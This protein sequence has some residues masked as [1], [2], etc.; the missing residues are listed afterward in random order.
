[1]ATTKKR[2]NTSYTIQTVNNTDIVTL[3]TSQVTITGNLSVLGVTTYVESTTTQVKD[4][5]IQLNQGETGA[6]VTGGSSGIEIDRGSSPDVQLRWNETV[7]A[8]QITSDGSTYS[9]IAYTTGSGFA[10]SVFSD[11]EPSV[12][13]NLNMWNYAIYSNTQPVV[14]FSDNVSISTTSVAPT[15][16]VNNVVVYASTVSGGGS[17]LYTSTADGANELATKSA[18]IKYSIIF[19]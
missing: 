15:A 14:Y 4:P 6:G 18:A 16:I 5:I 7:D 8:W 3:D 12:S 10:S 17:G 11:P 2:L 9:N 1:M 19:G 13:A